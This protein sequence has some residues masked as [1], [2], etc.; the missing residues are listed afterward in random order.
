MHQI[1]GVPSMQTM[2]V[3]DD[4]PG[5]LASA[6]HDMQVRHVGCNAVEPRMLTAKGLGS[7]LRLALVRA[8]ARLRLRHTSLTNALSGT[9]NPAA[10]FCNSSTTSQQG[11]AGPVQINLTCRM[12]AS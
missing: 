8:T 11:C 2:P 6:F 12:A 5:T 7:P 1:A 3:Q 4:L 10:Q 9:R